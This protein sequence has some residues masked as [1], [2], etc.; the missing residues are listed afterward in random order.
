MLKCLEKDPKDRYQTVAD[1][2]A[3]L[4]RFT[5]G[6]RPVAPPLTRWRRVKKWVKRNRWA[7]TATVLVM[8]LTI[9]GI[10]TGMWLVK[11]RDY[12]AEY[13]RDLKR[14]KSVTLVPAKG[15]PLWS[16]R[17]IGGVEVATSLAADGACTVGSVQHATVVLLPRV[18]I[19]RYSVEAELCV[20]QL[21]AGAGA[22]SES[23]VWD[24]LLATASIRFQQGH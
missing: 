22:G 7:T 18:D 16:D 11:P 4:D 24:Y 20:M 14:G 13:Q 21:P 10:A 2:A 5:A 1:L 9:A 8:V 19:D 17:P 15:I 6:Q 23:L 12:V 3:D